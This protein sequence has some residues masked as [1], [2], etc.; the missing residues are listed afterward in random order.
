MP[1][2]EVLFTFTVGVAISLS[3]NFQYGFSS[4]YLN[5][6]VDEFKAYINESFTKWE[7][8]LSSSQ[9]DLVFNLISNIWF[10]GFFCGIWLS[11]LLN[12][13]YGRRV[14]FISGNTFSLLASFLRALSIITHQPEILFFA[15]LLASICTAVTYQSC[16]LYLQ[17]ASP[18]EYRGVMSFISEICYAGMTLVGMGLGTDQLLGKHLFWLTA[19]AIIPSFLALLV[20]F[21]I[22]ETPKFLLIVKKDKEAALKSVHF[23]HGKSSNARGVLDEIEMEA[24]A[25][26]DEASFKQGTIDMFTQPH[27]RKALLLSCAALQN[28]VA[29]WSILLNSTQFLQD[30]GVTDW[31]NELSKW[32]ST[33]MSL[34][35][36]TATIMA[37]ALVERAGRRPLLLTFTSINMLALVLFTVFAELRKAVDGMKYGCVFA[38]LLYGFTY[39]G[40]VGPVSWFIPAELVPQ[41][42][43]SL[44][45]S[46]SYAINTLSVVITTF[47]VIPFYNAIG[48]YAFLILYIGPSIICMIYL[49]SYLPET[50]NREI[51]EIVDELKGNKK[52]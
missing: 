22:P 7:K 8:H 35:Y 43:R 39:G 46:L 44:N 45:Q 2:K 29:L 32:T 48:S 31:D 26:K 38:L 17:E 15:R 24:E 30:A 47:T 19:F 50:T 25:D 14:G 49:F 4:T 1:R 51:H 21:F 41:R 11:P 9:I 40:A 20:L 6:P 36:F 12:D 28:T 27:L 5:D 10:V 34:C 16:I 33:T 23:F 37:S 42:Y 3:A 13:R 18:T 52:K